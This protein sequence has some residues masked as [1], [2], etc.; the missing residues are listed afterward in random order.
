MQ[1]FPPCAR[2]TAGLFFLSLSLWMAACSPS[3]SDDVLLAGAFGFAFGDRPEGLGDTFLSE[4][5][6]IPA[7]NPPSPDN[8]FENYFYTVTPESHRIYQI[9]AVT[10]PD[11]TEPACAAMIDEMADELAQK[12]YAKDEAIINR[13]ELKWTL[14]RNTKRSVTLECMRAP[15]QHGMENGQ[16]YQLSLSYLDY[17]LATEAY[18]EWKKSDIPDKPDKY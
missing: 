5:R 4:L 2:R 12:Y 1:T 10:G 14:Q 15:A 7:G 8:R 6:T 3:G 13:T 16:P 11:L 17:N 18:K 9:S